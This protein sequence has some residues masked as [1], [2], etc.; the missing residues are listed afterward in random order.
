MKKVITSITLAPT[1]LFAILTAIWVICTIYRESSETEFYMWLYLDDK[2]EVKEWINKFQDKT[3]YFRYAFSAA[4]WFLI[5][6]E[7]I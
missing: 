3:A 4:I 7:I 2:P 1:I 6:K 5:I